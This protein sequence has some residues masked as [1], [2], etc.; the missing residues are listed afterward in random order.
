MVALVKEQHDQKVQLMN[1]EKQLMNE[2]DITS[3]NFQ[4]PKK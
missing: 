3:S 1:R 2:F 4:P